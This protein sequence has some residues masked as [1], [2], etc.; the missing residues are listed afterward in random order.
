MKNLQNGRYFIGKV[1]EFPVQKGRVVHV[2]GKGIAIFHL[3]TGELKAIENRCPH[4][5]G[6]LAEGIISGEFV[7]CPL[8]DWKINLND[9]QVQAPDRGCA[10]TYT[11][12]LV[13][14]NVYLLV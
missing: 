10:I 13:G 11:V 14:D 7:F 2:D 8:H 1:E 6:P 3:S 9:G 4:K 5:A 12:E